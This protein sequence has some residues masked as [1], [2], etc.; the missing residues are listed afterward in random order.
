MI[1]G[2]NVAMILLLDLFVVWDN[3]VKMFPPVYFLSNCLERN[4]RTNC[5]FGFDNTDV[6]GCMIIGSLLS[7]VILLVL[8]VTTANSCECNY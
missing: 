7:K 1:C 4:F 5:Y 6:F 2:L 3:I 8:G